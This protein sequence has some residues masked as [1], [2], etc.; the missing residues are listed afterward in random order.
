[1]KIDTMAKAFKELG[2]ATRLNI[3][4]NVIKAGVNG[5]PVGS[6][7]EELCIPAS[8]LS[9]HISS[10]ISAGLISQRR[11]GRVLYCV[12]EYDCLQSVID[13]LQEE[14]CIKDQ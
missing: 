1:M 7:Q 14:C 2:H 12:A 4:K 3:Y 6:I 11:E 8:T 9:H 5:T 10:L 13:F